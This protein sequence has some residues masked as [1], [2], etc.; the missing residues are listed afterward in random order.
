MY[1]PAALRGIYNGK[2]YRRGIEYHIMN[3]LAILSLKM[4]TVFGKE[5]PQQLQKQ[6]ESLRGSLHSQ[7]DDMI[8]TYHD[9]ASYYQEVVKPKYVCN[10]KGFSKFLD[11]YLV[12]VEVM[13]AGISAIR[14]RDFE[15]G[16]VAI[17]RYVKYFAAT[18]LHTYLL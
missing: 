18:D 9:L 10:E 7:E 12:Q 14:S 6:A 1:S 4:E 2:Q 17:D 13:L 16:L 5:V 3:A 11:N 8:N 15:G